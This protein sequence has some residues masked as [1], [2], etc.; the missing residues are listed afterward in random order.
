MSSPGVIE[1]TKGTIG[2]THIW[3]DDNIGES[4]HLHI[5]KL[6]LNFTND[7]FTQLRDELLDII[8]IMYPVK[9]F[10]AREINPVYLSSV[11]IPLLPFLRE[12]M[13]DEVFLEDL[14]II[15]PPK[16]GLINLLTGNLFH[17]LFFY[18]KPLSKSRCFKA[19]Q[20][21]NKENNKPRLSLYINQT[22]M[23]RL[24]K[25]LNSI[26]T[27]GYPYKN[28]YIIL[29]NDTMN[30]ADGQHRASCLLYLYGNIKI[31]VMRFCGSKKNNFKKH[32]M[33]YI[34]EFVKYIA[35]KLRYYKEN[36]GKI[37]FVLYR[38]M[39]EKYIKRI[40]KE[41][42]RYTINKPVKNEYT[43]RP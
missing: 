21:N 20:G 35:K 43:T 28:K 1:L 17:K 26:K 41:F 8:N 5:D 40:K 3:L 12:T 24:S 42:P 14:K 27:N 23:E 22:G 29:S 25:I 10:D 16:K 13:I 11:I 2:K 18:I 31:P 30:I 33:N 6:R 36:T 19:L 7:D 9:G 4:I 32:I 38:I 15:E 39:N 37:K 34:Y